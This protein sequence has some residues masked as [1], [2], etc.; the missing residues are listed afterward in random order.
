MK[1]ITLEITDYCPNNCP[2]C[3][4]KASPKGNSYLSLEQ[5]KD[6][7]KDEVYDRINISGGE[8]LANPDF[9]K[10]LRF[11]ESRSKTY[12]AIYSNAIRWLFYNANVIDGVRV[13]ANIS[14]PENIRKVH[15]L[16]RINQGRER[17]RPEVKFS[18]N[19]EECKDCF[20]C[21]H[22]VIRPDGTVAMGPCRKEINVIK[23]KRS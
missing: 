9:Y 14:V 21:T 1:E 11:C 13:E 18:G 6:I 2:Y 23:V 15:I 17:T 10:I 19:W 7:I 12:P 5:V 4:T 20:Q 3:S 16:K 8:P 22:R